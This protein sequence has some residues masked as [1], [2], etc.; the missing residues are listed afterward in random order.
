M[1]ECNAVWILEESTLASM[2]NACYGLVCIRNTL[3]SSIMI[4]VRVVCILLYEY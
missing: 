3:L 2:H 1:N 4:I